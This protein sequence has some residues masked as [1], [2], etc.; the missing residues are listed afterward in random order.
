MV[1]AMLL[2]TSILGSQMAHAAE[3]NVG[4]TKLDSE[5]S[6]SFI[7]EK[8]GPVDPNNPVVP[9][10]P[11]GGEVVDP[12]DPTD[13]EGLPGGQ[14]PEQAGPLMI[15]FAPNFDFGEHEI[16]ASDM[17]FPAI[18]KNT[19]A[20]DSKTFVNH[21]VQVKDTRGGSKGWNVTVK[22]TPLANKDGEALAASTMVI[23][24]SVAYG[25]KDSSLTKDVDFKAITF[26]NKEIPVMS[27]AKGEGGGRWW[28]SLAAEK[29]TTEATNKDVH[30][31]IPESD[32]AKLSESKYTS[33]L[34][35]EITGLEGRTIS[36][37]PQA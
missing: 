2:S 30:L 27:A 19:L 31:D 34:T 20:E 11:G 23:D 6:V 10:I 9:E 29:T 16:K 33:T 1:F 17:S 37:T 15:E 8:P 26:D 25:L 28:K 24:N 21:F 32:A 5:A 35:W 14:T 18:N 4:P 22:A 7:T 36:A 13:P 12:T 3:A